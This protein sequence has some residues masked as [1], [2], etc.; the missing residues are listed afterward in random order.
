VGRPPKLLQKFLELKSEIGVSTKLLNISAEFCSQS[1]PAELCAE[2]PVQ[3]VRRKD[4]KG[5]LVPRSGQI[6]EW[7]GSD[8]WLQGPWF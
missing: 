7:Q 1:G 3:A 5:E 4:L 2:M 6:C 8:R